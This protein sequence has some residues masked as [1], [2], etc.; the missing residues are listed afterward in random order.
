MKKV[1]ILCTGNSCRSQMADAWLN[2]FTSNN[3][4]VYSAGTKPE[5]VNPYAV[6]VMGLEGIDIS[7]NTSNNVDEYKYI[8]F[9]FV[10]TVCDNAKELCP[11]FP[12]SNLIHKSFPDPAKV[13]GTESELMKVYS[14]VSSDLKKFMSQFAKENLRNKQNLFAWVE[15]PV[16]NFPRAKRFYESLLELPIHESKIGEV[17]HGFWGHTENSVGGAI[18]QCGGE[19]SKVGPLV[20]FD[21]GNDLNDYLN[22]VESLG[23]KVILPKKCIA[24]EIGYYATFSDTEGNRLAL[25]SK[26]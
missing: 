12:S 5:T 6:K 9:D 20:Y 24:K 16:Q 10:I 7:E 18:V 8:K 21:G 4:E 15:I 14:Q 17:L 11:V 23:G 3:V 13:R 1:L 22:K 2:H 25:W 19:S 26:N